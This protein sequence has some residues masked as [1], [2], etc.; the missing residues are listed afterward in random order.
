ME[1]EVR[2][3]VDARLGGVEE[4]LAIEGGQVRRE[5][6]RA[7]PPE[8]ESAP[9]APGTSGRR[10]T[11][12]RSPRVRRWPSR[13]RRA[14]TSAS[15]VGG[16]RVS[17]S[18]RAGGARSLPSSISI[19]TSCSTKSG[20][21]SAAAVTRARIAAVSPDCPSRP[22][23]IS[24]AWSPPSGASTIRSSRGPSP[25]GL[26]LLEQVVSAAHEDQHRHDQLGRGQVLDEVEQGRLGG[27]DVV[28]RR[29][30]ADR[31]RR[32]SRPAAGRPRTSRRAETPSRSRPVTEASRSATSSSPTRPRSLARARS[33][34][35]SSSISAADRTISTSGQNVM[36]RPYGRQRPRTT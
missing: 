22:F 19:E 5:A 3:A 12:A 8:R 14:A 20:L 28:D 26:S 21:P 18:G 17:A 13:S 15:I 7:Q 36:P 30:R 29:R 27:V 2:F 32:A 11:R 33:G 31:D 6:P 9:P 4:L 24:S 1:P 35:S 23:T 34:G 10:R 25:H 16:M